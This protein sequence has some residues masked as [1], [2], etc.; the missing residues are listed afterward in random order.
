MKNNNTL[1]IGPYRQ[2]DINGLWAHSLLINLYDNSELDLYA[3]PIYINPESATNSISRIVADIEA[4]T[5]QKDTKYNTIIQHVPLSYAQVIDSID[6]NIIIPILDDQQLSDKN[7]N[8]LIEFNKIY[9]DNKQDYIKLTQFSNSKIN[10]K[11]TTISYEKYLSNT[12]KT[13]FDMGLFNHT[14]KLYHIS[15]YS[16]NTKAIHQ[17][18]AAYI[19]NIKYAIIN[20]I[21][22]ILFVLDINL[23]EKDMLDKFIQNCY[24]ASGCLQAVNRI[25]V[26]PITS[27]INNLSIAHNTGDAY[28]SLCD[29]GS[30]TINT[31]LATGLKKEVVLF[32]HKYNLSFNDKFGKVGGSL[33]IS[34]ADDII[35]NAM[36]NFMSNGYIY[37]DHIKQKNNPI[38]TLSLS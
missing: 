31:K 11:I 15:N 12:N 2:R 38:H 28:I 19:N 7:Y 36:K 13:K 30:D 17:I 6:S 10:K 20:N 23:S 21:S 34:K 8:K 3:R 37:K 33:Y 1:Y 29:Y 25:V 5:K 18:I 32:E 16:Q 24:E 27:D 35:N 22:L 14:K 4:K 26:A 9:V